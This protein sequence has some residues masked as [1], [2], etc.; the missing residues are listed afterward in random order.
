MWTKF[1]HAPLYIPERH[2]TV[3]A[4]RSASGPFT[5][6]V[7]TSIVDRW[8]DRVRINWVWLED[9][10]P[11][12]YSDGYRAG[13][14]GYAIVRRNGSDSTRIRPMVGPPPPPRIRGR[15]F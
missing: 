4:A 2:E 12:L 3:W 10:P 14:R 5:Q 15:D 11:T 6:A 13:E 8:F 1:D 7:I 9:S